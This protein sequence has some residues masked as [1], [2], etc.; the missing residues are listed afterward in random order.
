M[1]GSS[2]TPN[3]TPTPPSTL[4]KS[5]SGSKNQ[6]SIAGFFKKATPQPQSSTNGMTKPGG[7]VLPVN[8]L[9]K[10]NGIKS[11]PRGSDQSLTPAPSSDAVEEL[12]EEAQETKPVK[13]NGHGSPSGLPS[14]ASAVD[15]CEQVD[16]QV[17][18]GFYSPSRKVGF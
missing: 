6:I 18:K 1:A 8:G 7:P 5:T 11:S 10:K 13:V 16:D 12:I 14:P 4:K 17:R 9:K 2:K 15:A 3:D